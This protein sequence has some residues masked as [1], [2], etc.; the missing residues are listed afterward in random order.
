[1]LLAGC[2]KP[3]QSTAPETTPSEPVAEVPAQPPSP[4]AESAPVE[5][6]A[7]AAQ[8]EP[9][10]AKLEAP[11]ISIHEAIKEGDI[12]AVQQHL[13]TG[14]DVNAKNERGGTALYS[15]AVAGHNEI[16]ELLINKGAD[17]KNADQETTPLHLAVQETH[18]ENEDPSP[19]LPLD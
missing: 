10:P 9:P 6:V 2:G 11:D 12:Q 17:V 13:A 7:E 5:P 1:M 15:A 16:A 4:A 14:T 18:K 19:A 8:P 3:Q